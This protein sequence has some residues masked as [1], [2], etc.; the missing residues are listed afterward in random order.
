MQ[1]QVLHC[2]GIQMWSR[3][4]LYLQETKS[5]YTKREHMSESIKCKAKTLWCGKRCKEGEFSPVC[6]NV[7]AV[8][9]C[10]EGLFIA[11]ECSPW[12]LESASDSVPVIKCL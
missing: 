1:C 11:K 3:S 4:G 9:F 2:K 12:K 6:G 5:L 8:S 10:L 7:K